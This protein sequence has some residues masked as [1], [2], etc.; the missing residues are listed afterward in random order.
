MSSSLNKI[1][2]IDLEA[3]CDEPRPA[4]FDLEIIEIGI[5]VLDT[6]SLEIVDKESILVNPTTSWVTPFCTQ[7]TGITPESLNDAKSF[8]KAVKYLQETY[9]TKNKVWAS[10]GDY[11]RTMFEAQCKRENVEYP[12]GV[13]HINIKTIFSLFGGMPKGIGVKAAVEQLGLTW[14]GRQHSGLD[15]SVNTANI[16]KEIIKRHP[17]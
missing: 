14:E 16:F 6:R 9:G 13:G 4:P 3:T 1:L 5:C 8:A 7:L 12:F 15:D 17:K 2:V 11:D 10:W